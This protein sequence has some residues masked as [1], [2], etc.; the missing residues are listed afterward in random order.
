MAQSPKCSATS[1]AERTSLVI[2]MSIHSATKNDFSFVKR[3]LLNSHWQPFYSF[4]SLLNCLRQEERNGTK[5]VSVV[6]SGSYKN[7]DQSEKLTQLL[8]KQLAHM[9][10]QNKALTQKL[11]HALNQIDF[12][13]Q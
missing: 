11:D 7:E 2:E 4:F 8:E 10:E 1:F 6:T 13:N 9:N 5:M 12:L 3:I